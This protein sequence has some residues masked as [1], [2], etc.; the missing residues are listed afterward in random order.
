[1]SRTL[2]APTTITK[3]VITN[4]LCR[5]PANASRTRSWADSGIVCFPSDG[6]SS[7]DVSSS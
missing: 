2:I 1:M 7:D 5:A 3:K 4:T 6:T